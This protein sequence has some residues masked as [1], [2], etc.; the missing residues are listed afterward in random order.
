[1]GGAELIPGI[2]QEKKRF[3]QTFISSSQHQFYPCPPWG[4]GGGVER[5]TLDKDKNLFSR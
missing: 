2:V 4:G 1:M 5:N 3:C